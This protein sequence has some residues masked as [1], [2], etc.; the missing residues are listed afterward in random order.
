MNELNAAI[1]KSQRRLVVIT[2]PHIK[3]DATNY[4]VYENGVA[5]QEASLGGNNVTSIWVREPDGETTFVGDCW[6]GKS[7]WIDYV[8]TNG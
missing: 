5:A 6:P 3:Q 2:D 7:V 4:P 8:N 1:Q